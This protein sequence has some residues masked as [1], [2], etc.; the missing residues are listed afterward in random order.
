[1][2]RDLLSRTSIFRVGALPD[3]Y[4]IC[5]PPLCGFGDATDALNS[6][7]EVLCMRELNKFVNDNKNCVQFGGTNEAPKIV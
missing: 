6:R 1:M 7:A 2:A 5:H 4:L 3:A